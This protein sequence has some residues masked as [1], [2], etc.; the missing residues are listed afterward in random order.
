MAAVL[1]CRAGVAQLLP[2][3]QLV[4]DLGPFA[5]DGGGGVPEVPAQLGVAQ[6]QPG[7]VGERDAVCSGHPMSV[8]VAPPP[9]LA[10]ISARWTVPTPVRSR[11]QAAADMHEARRV[12]SGAHLGARC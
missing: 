1:D 3:G 2:V 9:V 11:R 12:A 4:D 5:A 8:T 6:C 10:R 7:R